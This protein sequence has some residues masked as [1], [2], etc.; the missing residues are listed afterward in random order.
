MEVL[1]MRILAFSM[2]F[3]C[4][5]PIFLSR[6][7]PSSR[8]DSSRVPPVRLMIWMDSRFV[9]PF[10]RST[11]STARAAKWSLSCVRIF[12]LSVVRAMLRRSRRNSCSF[13]LLSMLISCRRFWA[14]EQASRNPAMMVMGWR[15][16]FTRISAC[17]S[18]SPQSTTTE[19]VPSPTSSSCTLEMST[20]T[21]AAALSTYS[22]LRIV[23][24]SFVTVT[25]SPRPMDCKILSIPFGPSVVFT[26]SATA[27]APT[28]EAKRAVSPFSSSAPCARIGL[29]C[30]KPLAISVCFVDFNSNR[31]VNSREANLFAYVIRR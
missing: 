20:R 29:D 7:N 1:A 24:P 9:E 4:P 19:V 18:S 6:M 2:R 5:T 12:E 13:F 27:I 21:F 10:R 22:D 28:K 17:L 16:W 14:T 11:A 30:P 31:R 23:A 15:C 26:R 8:K 3:G 25:V